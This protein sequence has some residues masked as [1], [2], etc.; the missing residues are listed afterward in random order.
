M[1]S[2]HVGRFVT[3]LQFSSLASANGKLYAINETNGKEVCKIK[4]SVDQAKDLAFDTQ[5]N[6]N[7]AL[8]GNKIKVHMLDCKLVSSRFYP[9]VGDIH[10]LA[11]DG[12]NNKVILDWYDMKVKVFSPPPS[13]NLKKELPRLDISIPSHVGIGKE[14]ALY[15]TNSSLHAVLVYY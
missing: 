8:R 13:S 10:S 1:E 4:T 2:M 3:G 12:S 6:L 15:V 9:L 5:G 7:L 11:L 14:C